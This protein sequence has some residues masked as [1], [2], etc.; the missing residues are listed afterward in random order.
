MAER[1]NGA[2]SLGAVPVSM[3]AQEPCP[4]RFSTGF[5]TMPPHLLAV[6]PDMVRT[7]L[8]ISHTECATVRQNVSKDDRSIDRGSCLASRWV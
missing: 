1:R 6:S 2:V 4:A 3:D 7:V 8:A 5:S